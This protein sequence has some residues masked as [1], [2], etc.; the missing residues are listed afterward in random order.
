MVTE[1]I[2]SGDKV[3]E[4]YT[5]RI[6]MIYLQS[7]NTEHKR[8]N[9]SFVMSDCSKRSKYENKFVNFHRE[10]NLFRHVFVRVQMWRF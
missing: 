8:N 10:E 5:F 6:G 3:D 1:G 4:F 9:D 7:Q 2:K